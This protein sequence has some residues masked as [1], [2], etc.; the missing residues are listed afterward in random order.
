MSCAG[1]TPPANVELRSSRRPGSASSGASCCRASAGCSTC[2]APA[3]GAAAPQPAA[4]RGCVDRAGRRR[5]CVPRGPHLVDRA[6]DRS[7]PDGTGHRGEGGR[8]TG[9]AATATAEAAKATAFVTAPPAPVDATPS[10][11]RLE[12]HAIGDGTFAAEL[13]GEAETLTADELRAAA[14]A[15]A[16][17]GGSARVSAVGV[18]ASTSAARQAFDILVAAG[19]PTTIDG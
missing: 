3:P 13:G 14:E 8:G 5:G 7:S 18:D 2:S 19:V 4:P 1:S 16:R 17:A 9:P 15:L 11:L 12:V 6:A 10:E